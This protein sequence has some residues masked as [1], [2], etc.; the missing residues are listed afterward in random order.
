MLLRGLAVLDN[1]IG[2]A[3]NTRDD[4]IQENIP[5]V[6]PE[7][8]GHDAEEHVSQAPANRRR[9][10]H[11][12]STKPRFFAFRHRG[13]ATPCP[14]SIDNKIHTYHNCRHP[15]Q[16]IQHHE[17]SVKGTNIARMFCNRASQPSDQKSAN[18]EHPVRK[19]PFH[20]HSDTPAMPKSS[21]VQRHTARIAF[22]KVRLTPPRPAQISNSSRA[23]SSSASFTATSPST[24][25]R[26]SMMRWS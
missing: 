22:P 5:K 16:Q 19:P 24:A 21:A 1:A 26:P 4:F 18:D 7:H 14:V 8:Y 12:A 23:G 3:E 6:K 11:Q 17:Q 20:I 10:L 2:R 13:A 9:A 15:Q 25:S